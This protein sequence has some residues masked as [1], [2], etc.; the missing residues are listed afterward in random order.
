MKAKYSIQDEDMYNF[1][2]AGFMMGQISTG[3]VVTASERRGRPKA[4]QQGHRER[5]TVI[6]GI[7][8]TGWAIPPFI[9]FKGRYHLF[10]W[11]KEDTIPQDWVIAVS[12]T[13]ELGLQWLKH[14]D[15][16]T[17]KR[18]VGSYRL[19]AIDGRESHDSLEFDLVGYRTIDY[20][21]FAARTILPTQIRKLI[22]FQQASIV[23]NLDI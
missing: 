21:S 23:S 6:R 22:W 8:A 4:V 10:A 1:D 9:I 12:A 11:Y 18:V 13:N 2:E 15:E 3:A 19:L 16:H 14:F 17:K 5:T 20:L 7:N